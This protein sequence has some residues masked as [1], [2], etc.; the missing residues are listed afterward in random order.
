VI[1]RRR[2]IAVAPRPV[3]HLDAL[4][5]ILPIADHQKRKLAGWRWS[6]P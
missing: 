5:A 2:Y 6:P 3:R 4:C 1:R